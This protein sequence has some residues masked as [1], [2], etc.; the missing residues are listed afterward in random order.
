M[1][2]E[3]FCYFYSMKK[4]YEQRTPLLTKLFAILLVLI[5]AFI[6]LAEL[7]TAF[8]YNH[9][10]TANSPLNSCIVGSEYLFVSPLEFKELPR[11]N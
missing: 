5:F 4:D 3:Y 1:L 2:L 10:K 7:I 9:V 8:E 6:P 11:F